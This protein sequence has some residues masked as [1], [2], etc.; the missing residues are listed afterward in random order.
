MSG[1]AEKNTCAL[2][3][4]IAWSAAMGTAIISVATPLTQALIAVAIGELYLGLL[5]T[6]LSDGSLDLT[7][8]WAYAGIVVALVFLRGVLHIFSTWVWAVATSTAS[9][10]HVSL[11]RTT[12][13]TTSTTSE[14]TTAVVALADQVVN[15]KI[16]FQRLL[17]EIPAMSLTAVALI[18]WFAPVLG[19]ISG[20]TWFLAAWF[21]RHAE[22]E[23]RTSVGNDDGARQLWSSFLR[24]EALATRSVRGLHLEQGRQQVL[25]RLLLNWSQLR[26]RQHQAQHAATLPLHILLAGSQAI[27]AVIGATLVFHGQ[28]ELC[29]LITTLVVSTSIAV[30]MEQLPTMLTQIAAGNIAEQQL[31]HPQ[32]TRSLP[33][34]TAPLPSSLQ[35]RLINVHHDSADNIPPDVLTLVPGEIVGMV[36]RTGD[37]KEQLASIWSGRTTQS[38]WRSVCGSDAAGWQELQT[39]HPPD[40]SRL[41]QSV[42]QAGQLM[43]GT[44]ADNLRLGQTQ[45]TDDE[46]A[47]ALRL[48]SASDLVERFSNGLAHQVGEQG[49]C[50]SGGQ[51]Q[52]LYLARAIAARPRFLCLD[53]ATSELDQ[54]HERGVLDGLRQLAHNSPEKTGVLIVS[55]SAQLL[56][57][58]DRIV[59]ISRGQVFAHGNHAELLRDCHL[60]PGLLG[61]DPTMTGDDQQTGAHQPSGAQIKCA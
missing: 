43:S 20:I 58:C 33:I 26:Q 31:K 61:L 49:I 19:V 48:A 57:G 12:L 37:G 36:G 18:T 44:I 28:L 35:V 30:R 53:Q 17:S 3:I 15:G 38:R 52:R 50:L 8:A 4:P 13:N 42:T 45:L 47:R 24:D 21:L 29:G 55:S 60:Y 9:R 56:A 6:R 40:R 10:L 22:R 2:S 7:R 46:L 32:Q 59:V 5:I 11:V 25:Q 14:N 27:I 54:H 41:I 39:L 16:I 1:I 51:R 23:M 34:V